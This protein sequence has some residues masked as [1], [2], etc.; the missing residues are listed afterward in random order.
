MCAVFVLINRKEDYVLAN[1]FFGLGMILANSIGFFYLV[2]T[3]GVSLGG[4]SLAPAYQ[5][6]R[7]EFS[8]SVSQFFLSIYQF[9]PIMIVSYI[10][11]DFMAGQF[12]VI[13]QIVS[14]F[15]S[16][17]NIFFY[18]VY[19]NICYEL[20]KNLKRGMAVWKQYNGLNFLMLLGI[21]AVFFW[22]AELI[23]TYFKID[24]TQM[25]SVVYYFRMALAIPMLIAVSM[26]LRQL[27]FAFEKNRI[28]ITITI[29][30]TIANLILLLALT[31]WYQLE[32]SFFSIIFIE[33]IVIVLY[34]F[35]LGKNLRQ[36]LN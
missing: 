19:A 8:F 24:A 1:L 27:M 17:Q 32:G 21:V 29:V 3:Y 33:F 16:Y 6:L 35:I 12:R 25:E 26:P 14:I 4:F 31:Q 13:D 9:F 36:A 18:F 11:G 15:K 23:F 2:K 30:A 5:I 34:V 10:G 28:Y 7:E 20:D 22:K